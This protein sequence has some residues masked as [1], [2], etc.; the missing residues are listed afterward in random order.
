MVDFDLANLDKPPSGQDLN[1]KVWLTFDPPKYLELKLGW[2]Y[3]NAYNLNVKKIQQ[4]SNENRNLT[5]EKIR[6]ALSFPLVYPPEKVD[7]HLYCEGAD[8][9]PLNLPNIAKVIGNEVQEEA[10]RR[11]AREV[12]RK[13][14][15]SLRGQPGT[16]GAPVLT[17]KIYL[18]DILGALEKQLMYVPRDL[19]EAY[20]LSILTPVVSLAKMSKKI[21]RAKNPDSKGLDLVDVDFEIPATRRQG[22]L[23]WSYENTTAM[24]D[25]GWK[26]GKNFITQYGADLPDRI[27][28][29]HGHDGDPQQGS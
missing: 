11:L 29:P 25:A 20:G 21:F 27:D 15:G 6:A 1:V 7:G 16:P 17:L 5:A 24:W 18:F 28:A 23:D 2:F 22:P 10:G 13:V 4:F 14:I 12:R 19:W 3:A 26:A 9:D 8:V